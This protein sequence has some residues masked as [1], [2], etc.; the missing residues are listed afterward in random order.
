MSKLPKYRCPYCDRLLYKGHII[1]IAIKCP[2][3]KHI[4]YYEILEMKQ[5]IDEY[6]VRNSKRI[7]G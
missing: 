2:R 5:A 4:I 6:R 3:C 7:E 1:E